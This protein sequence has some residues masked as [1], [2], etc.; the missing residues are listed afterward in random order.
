MA[1]ARALATST[2]LEARGVGTLDALALGLAEAARERGRLAVLDARRGEA[3]AAL[4]AA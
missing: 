3:F 2:G 4:Y 1:S